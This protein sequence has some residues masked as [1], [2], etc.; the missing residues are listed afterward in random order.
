MQVV[1]GYLAWILLMNVLVNCSC[2]YHC[3]SAVAEGSVAV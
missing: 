2:G 3:A 1:I